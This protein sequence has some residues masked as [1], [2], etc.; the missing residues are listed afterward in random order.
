FSNHKYISFEE[1]QNISSRCKVEKG[2][3][4]MTR[5]GSIG[6]AVLVDWDYECSIY[7]SLALLKVNEKIL[8]E[9]LVHYMA[10]DEFRREILSKSL[11][12]AIPQK[13][14]LVDIGRVKVYF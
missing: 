11:L 14:N 9:Y 3:I 12:S 5:I 10:T 6:D 7:V 1:H 13:I 4:L 2:D 8:P